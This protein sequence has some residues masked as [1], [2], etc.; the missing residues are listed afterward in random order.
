[1]SR[2]WWWRGAVI[3][4]LLALVGWLATATEWVDVEVPLPARGEAARNRLYAT[5]QLARRLGA[6][7]ATP[8][9]LHE[10]PPANAT[11]L[12][13]SWQWDM[14]PDR[15][16]KLK[17]WVEN[18]G[19]LVLYANATEQDAL[20]DWLQ[21][22]EQRGNRDDEDSEDDEGEDPVD[23]E[24]SPTS[25]AADGDSTRQPPSATEPGTTARNE[26]QDET[27]EER[28]A[29]EKAEVE[30]AERAAERAAQRAAE[31]ALARARAEA[32]SS[33][34]TSG[35]LKDRTP[36]TVVAEPD[37]A[38]RA[39]PDGNRNFRLCHRAL[40]WT[41]HSARKTVWSLDGVD[42]PMLLRVAMGR[43]LVTVIGPWNLL[44]ND[45]VLEAD[46][47]LIAAA[48][49]RLRAGV[50]VWFVTEEARP[51]LLAWLWD[52][53]GAAVLLGGLALGLGLWRGAVRFGPRIAKAVPGRRSMA[54]QIGGTARFLRREGPEALLTAQVRALDQAAR[55]HLRQYDL[56]DRT[57]RAHAI[58]D[59]TGLDAGALG[60]A[61]DIG[62]A[63][64][65]TDLPATLALLETARRR[66]L[67]PGLRPPPA[68]KAASSTPSSP[69]P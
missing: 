53:A 61:L 49:L 65:R 60:R 11:M 34:A 41:L 67:Q 45:R 39:Y 3:V 18:G 42:G 37:A 23:G 1:M 19:H 28:E 68:A 16:Q 21:V 63:R 62:L 31:R 8:T 56:L 10:M 27:E 26:R 22:D 32:A 36:C 69:N 52:R 6:T 29:R 24:E 25:P 57:R 43:G 38:S 47:G 50:P 2:E 4:L 58:A 5:Q 30:R 15:V 14:F 55:Q 44:D 13:T 40:G 48:A 54:E 17:G 59:V 35:L 7:V 33:P 51:P 12:L 66:L 46:H 20:K 64:R 9:G